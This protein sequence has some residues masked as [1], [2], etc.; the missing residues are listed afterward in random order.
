M[1][2]VS[3]KNYSKSEFLEKLGD[4]IVKV[5][6]G[7]PSGGVLVFLPS[8]SLLRK[9]ERLWNPAGNRSNR[10]FWSQF[11]SSDG[12]SVWDRLE[13]L[14]H[15]VIM[16]PSGSNQAEFEEKKQEYMD[17]VDQRGGCV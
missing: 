9:C 3:H 1:T 11:D 16:E 12:P 13:A 17:S 14:R 7:I 8:Y 6:E 5:V 15:H 10:R 4:S 2:I